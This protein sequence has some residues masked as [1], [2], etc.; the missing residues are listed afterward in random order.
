[1]M[2]PAKLQSV[3]DNLKTELGEALLGCDVWLAQDGFSI[4]SYQS[5]PKAVAFFNRVADDLMMSLEKSETEFPEIGEYFYIKLA[6]NKGTI[7][8]LMG[9]YRIGLLFDLNKLQLGFMFNV[10]LPQFIENL[11]EVLVEG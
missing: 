4:A 10:M 3:I 2:S 1:M 6:D 11:E 9:D 5:M 7:V 8:V